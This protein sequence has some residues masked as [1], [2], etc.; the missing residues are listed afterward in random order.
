MLGGGPTGGGP[1]PGPT[2]LSRDPLKFLLK[3]SEGPPPGPCA[4]APRM[5]S[6][7][8]IGSALRI[9]LSVL[10]RRFPGTLSPEGV[11]WICLSSGYRILAVS[12][13]YTILS[14]SPLRG[15]E[16]G[17]PAATTICFPNAVMVWP[18]RGEGAGPMFWKVNHRLD[19]ILN[20]ARSSRSVPFSVRPP[21]M[22]ITSLTKAAECPSRG[23]GIYPMQS[24]CVHTTC[25]GS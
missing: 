7:C 17:S 10:G 14:S 21:N 1:D 24:S 12:K 22:Y 9:D 15:A 3:P 19:V 13:M 25:F 16:L 8:L 2:M 11:C 23:A 20:A 4:G 5:A 18:D 6:G